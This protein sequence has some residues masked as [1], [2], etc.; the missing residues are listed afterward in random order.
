MVVMT[1]MNGDA[2]GLGAVMAVDARDEIPDTVT[3]DITQ[4]RAGATRN[5]RTAHDHFLAEGS[6]FAE[7]CTLPP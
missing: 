7:V 6:H 2:R 1:V 5:T 4:R 3:P